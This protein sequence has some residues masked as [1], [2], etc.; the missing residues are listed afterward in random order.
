MGRQKQQEWFFDRPAMGHLIA[1][2]FRLGLNT[3]EVQTHTGVYPYKRQKELMDEATGH[4][5]GPRAGR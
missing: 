2:L 5:V 4:R 3:L 1:L